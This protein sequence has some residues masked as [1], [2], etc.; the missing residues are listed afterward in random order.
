MSIETIRDDVRHVVA[1]AGFL[2]TDEVTDAVF[3][4]IRDA[5]TGDEAVEAVARGL[6]KEADDG[7]FERVDEW[8]AD[9]DR[10]EWYSDLPG[11]D[12]EDCEYYRNLARAAIAALVETIG[13]K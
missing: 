10:Q 13:G 7:C 12:Y 11:S 5:L 4:L 2:S 1:K 9:K 3:D 8:E 6:A